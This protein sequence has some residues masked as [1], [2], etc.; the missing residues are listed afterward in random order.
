VPTSPK[1]KDGPK[2]QV[3]SRL[4]DRPFNDKDLVKPDG[5]WP[6]VSEVW[7]DTVSAM[8]DGFFKSGDQRP[9][10]A[11]CVA[12]ASW[13]VVLSDV[14]QAGTRIDGA[15]TADSKLERSLRAEVLGTAKSLGILTQLEH[16]MKEERPQGALALLDAHRGK[17]S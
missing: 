7:D 16:R 6:E 14:E 8:P 2:R 1:G 4:Q 9:L 13:L 10:Q 17:A 3:N 11:Y 12:V 15:E 5:L